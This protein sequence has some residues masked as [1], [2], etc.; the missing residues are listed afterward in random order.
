MN[1]RAIFETGLK[2]EAFLEAH[3]TDV[4]RDRW[5]AVYESAA[6][7]EAQRSLLAGFTR[8]MN[9]LCLSGA[10]CGDC[11]NQCPIMQRIAEAGPRIDLRFI[12]RD[13]NPD[14]RS[15]LAINGGQRVPVVVFLAEDFLECGRYG[16]RTLGTYR[17]MAAAQL[18]PA[19]PTGVS[20]AD[21]TATQLVTQEWL[22][23]FERIQLMLRLSARLRQLHGD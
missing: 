4:H 20:P 11:V 8:Q 2:Y 14:L 19:C 21:R 13:V 15:E 9:V 18:G 17:R 7:T 5:R 3:G 22:D 16:D 23:E 12:D 1:W 10:W 6:L